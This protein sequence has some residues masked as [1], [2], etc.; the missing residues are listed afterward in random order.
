MSFYSLTA[1]RGKVLRSYRVDH[2]LHTR[3]HEELNLKER[4]G[5]ERE[6]RAVVVPGIPKELLDAFANRHNGT[7]SGEDGEDYNPHDYEEFDDDSPHLPCPLNSESS[8]EYY[9]LWQGWT[10][11]NW[12]LED[13]MSGDGVLEDRV[14]EIVYVPGPTVITTV[15]LVK[16]I[17]L[18]KGEQYL[19]EGSIVQVFSWGLN[20]NSNFIYIMTGKARVR[21]SGISA[22]TGA[23]GTGDI[24]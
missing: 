21:G 15:Y 1:F 6:R 22:R 3:C 24:L 7:D 14:S 10:S 23:R 20:L 13:E 9:K 16:V 5:G 18:F 4:R 2:Y 12:N 11:L 8:K 17:K 19:T